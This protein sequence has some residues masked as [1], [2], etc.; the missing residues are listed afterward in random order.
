MRISLGLAGRVVLVTGGVRGVG[1]GISTVFADQGASVVTCARRPVDGL[2]YDFHTCDIRDDESVKALIEAIVADHG[3][4]DVVVNNAGGSPYVLA[5]D[6][7]AKFSRKILELNLLGAAVGLDA[8]QRRDAAAGLRRIDRQHHQR[9][10]QAS[11]PGDRGLWRGE[12]RRR[13][14]DDHARGRVGAES[15]GEL[16]GGGHGRDRAVRTVLR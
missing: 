5:A 4:L 10:R 7:S 11:H 8:R 6:A 15:A 16:G 12:G 3:R 1:A 2:P 9:Q 14:H 13:E